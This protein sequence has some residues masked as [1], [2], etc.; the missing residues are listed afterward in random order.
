MRLRYVLMA[1]IMVTTLVGISSYNR[2]SVSHA[3]ANKS[4]R[5]NHRH[6]SNSTNSPASL[7]SGFINAEEDG[8]LVCREA[9]PQEAIQLLQRDPDVRLRPISPIRPN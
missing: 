9:T 7:E 2:R 1:L 5:L 4:E 8:K 6:K 3:D